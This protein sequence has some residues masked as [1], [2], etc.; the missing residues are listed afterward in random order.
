M[1]VLTLPTEKTLR[2]SG[3]SFTLGTEYGEL[4]T[5]E[6]AALEARKR[7]DRIV[8][9][10]RLRMEEWTRGERTDF[11]LDE[12]SENKTYYPIVRY[13]E[14]WLDEATVELLSILPEHRLRDLVVDLPNEESI[15]IERGVGYMDL[16]TDF[17][18]L[19][20]LRMSCWDRTVHDVLHVTDDE[21]KEQR[22]KYSRGIQVKPAVAVA[23]G[24]IEIY[25]MR[26]GDK[27]E[28]GK[29]VNKRVAEE[30]PE[31]MWP[32]IAVQTAIIVEGVFGDTATVDVLNSQLQTLLT[33]LKV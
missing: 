4:Y 25:S 5:V 9:M 30:T 18:R 10:T 24:K 6:A 21:Y 22:Y 13:I 27:V 20:G 31:W 3:D 1:A 7:R 32:L 17:V 14:E 16:P 28:Y 11:Y 15:E 12:N 8:E 23:Y 2:G 26:K 33:T 19:D 29:Y